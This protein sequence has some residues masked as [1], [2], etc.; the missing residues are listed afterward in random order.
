M[1]EAGMCSKCKKECAPKSCLI[2]KFGL[3]DESGTV[4]NVTCFEKLA[5][6]VFGLNGEM[7][8]SGNLVGFIN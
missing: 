2:L 3:S 7:V 5:D 8:E 1:K 6:R 4:Y